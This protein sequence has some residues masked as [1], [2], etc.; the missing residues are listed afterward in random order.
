MSEKK[1]TEKTKAQQ[2][3]EL[4]S[5]LFGRFTPH[6]DDERF[7]NALLE[8]FSKDIDVEEQLKLFHAWCLD[9][10]PKIIANTRFRLRSWLANNANYTRT[11]RHYV[12]AAYQSRKSQ[13]Q[14]LEK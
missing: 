5:K 3:A 12:A 2:L 13:P 7:F 1:E 8:E 10:H 6:H 4:S 9:Q 11:R 14:P